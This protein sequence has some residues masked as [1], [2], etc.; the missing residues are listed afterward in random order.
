MLGLVLFFIGAVALSP[1][2][3]N[4]QNKRYELVNQVNVE[5]PVHEAFEYLGNSANA[6]VW[7][8]F[9]K[10]VIPLNQ[11]KIEDG[12]PGSMRRCICMDKSPCDYWDE[13]ILEVLKDKKRVLSIYNLNGFPVTMEGLVTEQIY[14]STGASSCTVGLTL[15]KSS[16][17]LS[18]WQRV[19]LKLAGYY[20]ARVFRGNLEN[21]KS[22]VES[23]K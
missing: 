14:S 5:V 18:W 17:N 15:Y 1:F 9:V 21:I 16:E 10:E 23:G 13:E 20:V 11:E 22:D 7:S 4:K 19:K 12:K 2:K 8:V 3:Y 6:R